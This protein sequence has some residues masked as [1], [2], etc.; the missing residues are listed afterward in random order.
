[1]V[2]EVDVPQMSTTEIDDVDELALHAHDTTVSVTVDHAVTVAAAVSP[3]WMWVVKVRV[4]PERV[5]A[6]GQGVLESGLHV[7]EA[8]T[9][10]DCY[11]GYWNVL[12]W[13][14]MGL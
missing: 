7:M 14:L 9:V 6:I 11:T 8:V 12:S 3:G 2:P 13:F 1:M 10:L 4:T 5:V